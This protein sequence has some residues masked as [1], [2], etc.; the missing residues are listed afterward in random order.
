MERRARR[1]PQR[2]R[3]GEGGHCGVD[4]IEQGSIRRI[5][6]RI[7]MIAYSENPSFYSVSVH[8]LREC[9]RRTRP[10][11]KAKGVRIVAVRALAICAADVDTM[12]LIVKGLLGDT[13]S[14]Q[15]A[16]C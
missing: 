6:R 8:Q 5:Q 13:R 15:Y 14:D 3:R 10:H 2:W 1:F 12:S 16:H 9:A 4:S 7:L 11:E